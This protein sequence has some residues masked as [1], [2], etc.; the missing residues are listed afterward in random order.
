MQHLATLEFPET[1]ASLLSLSG[2]KFRVGR[3][4]NTWGL[5]DLENFP[6]TFTLRVTTKYEL[7]KCIPPRIPGA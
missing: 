6:A 2:A 1:D 3:K 4:N 5:G 7:H